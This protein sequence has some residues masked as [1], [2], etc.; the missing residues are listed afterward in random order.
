[1]VQAD[2]DQWVQRGNGVAGRLDLWPSHIRHAVDDLPLQVAQ[3]NGVVVDD[4]DGP[5]A[6]RGKVEQGRGAQPA[7]TD[8]KHPG[9]FQASLANRANLRNDEV[10]GVSFHLFGRKFG[11]RFDKGVR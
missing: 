3:V 8:D 7:G 1:M 4:P 5:D 9:V 10:P 6:G 11:C 2:V